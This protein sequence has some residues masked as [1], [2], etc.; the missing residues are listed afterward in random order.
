M[1]QKEDKKN[2]KRLF[3][4]YMLSPQF[5]EKI[6]YWEKSANMLP[7]RWNTIKNLHITIIPPWNEPHVAKI[8]QVLQHSSQVKEFSLTFTDIGPGPTPYKPRLIWTTADPS[9]ELS[10]LRN[11]LHHALHQNPEKRPF[12]PH[13]T[14]GKLFTPQH[15]STIIPPFRSTFQWEEKISKI[16]LVESML[17]PQGASY[18][19]LETIPLIRKTSEVDFQK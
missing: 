6:L 4:A 7:V 10:V 16:Y 14:L 1:K 13:V 17:H 3:I 11:E 18:R 5:Q 15:I 2:A 19:V 8:I 12:I 9:E